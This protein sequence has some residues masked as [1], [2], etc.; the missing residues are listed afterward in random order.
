MKF[1]RWRIS[2]ERADAPTVL[3]TLRRDPWKLV[4]ERDAEWFD[5]RQRKLQEL[6]DQIAALAKPDPPEDVSE[7]AV[8][9]LDQ[10]FLDRKTRELRLLESRFANN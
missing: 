4:R 3:D 5:L 7:F 2:V 8:P 9:H 1:W 6:D 10:A